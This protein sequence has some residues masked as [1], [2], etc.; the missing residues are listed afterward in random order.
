MNKPS[1]K[2]RSYGT[3]SDFELGITLERKS[4]NV[5][6]TPGG[7]TTVGTIGS[8]K[9]REIVRVYSEAIVNG[10]KWYYITY[11]T[12][13][14]TKSGYIRAAFIDIPSRIYNYSKV[15]TSGTWTCDY[16]YNDHAGVDIAGD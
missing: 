10:E 2:S 15:L 7:T 14:S 5:Y 8:S 1:S 12:S 4:Y 16:G 9:S 13:T 6:T 11:K 3:L